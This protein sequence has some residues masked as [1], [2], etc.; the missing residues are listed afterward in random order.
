MKNVI[1]L[2][3]ALFSLSA[4]AA[5]SYISGVQKVTFR[6]G[7]GTDNKI[8]KMLATD[9]AIT[10]MEAGET[11]TK[12]KDG[13]GNEG[14]VLNRFITTE[15]P[16]ILKY[17]WMKSKFEKQKK[18][19]EVLAGNKGE[20]GVQV[21]ELQT[22]LAN[23]TAALEQV[24]KEYE[25]LKTG[26]ADYIGLK[27]KYDSTVKTLTAQNNKVDTLE[28]Q[29]SVYYIKWFLAGSGVLVLGW[30]LGLISRKKKNYSSIRL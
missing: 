17:K 16:A 2:F 21:K 25:E 7:P 9:Q 18:N 3:V 27:T 12:V 28:S 6:T 26:S 23:T 14:Y 30:I 11:W 29:I 22:K 5:K 20:L 15:T 10:V 4:F 13:E 8:I 1:I 24:T 19:M